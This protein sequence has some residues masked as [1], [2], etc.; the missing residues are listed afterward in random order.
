MH[1]RTSS[2]N[3][4]KAT[5]KDELSLRKG[6]LYQVMEKCHDGW[7]KGKNMKTGKSGVFPGNYVKE[8]SG[9]QTKKSRRKELVCVEDGNLIDLS[10]EDVKH[11]GDSETDA[12]RLK[13]LKAIRETLRQAQQQQRQQSGA[14][15]NKGEKYR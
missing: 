1:H 4:Y 11:E 10:D 3:S 7:F 5:Q 2:S 14:C 15:K 12:D 9:K 13:K 8:Y 6:E